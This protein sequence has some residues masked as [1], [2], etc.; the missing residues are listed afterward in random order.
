MVGLLEGSLTACGQEKSFETMKK[1]ACFYFMCISQT[2]C[3]EVEDGD[4]PHPAGRTSASCTLHKTL[5]SEESVA[6]LPGV[7]LLPKAQSV[8]RGEVAV[9]GLG[10]LSKGHQLGQGAWEC[11]S[12]PTSCLGPGLTAELL[13]VPGE[14][15]AGIASHASNV[16]VTLKRKLLNKK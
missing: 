14:G 7:R 9:V 2:C 13:P 3:R 10:L 15:Q 16:A 8:T 6:V 1:S 5:T 11:D 4:A 12:S